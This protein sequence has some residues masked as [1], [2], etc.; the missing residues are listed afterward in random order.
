MDEGF[1]EIRQI[2]WKFEG[3]DEEKRLWSMWLQIHGK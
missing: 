3:T 2:D 1:E